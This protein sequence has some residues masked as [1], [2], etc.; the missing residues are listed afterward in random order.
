MT[1]G[2][3]TTRAAAAEERASTPNS[4]GPE[5]AA[6]GMG[7]SSERVG[8]V[9]PGQV[10]TDGVRD[11][12]ELDPSPGSRPDRDADAGEGA[13]EGI[14]PKAGYPSLDPRHE[15]KPYRT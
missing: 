14:E 13:V 12:S 15:D 6:G 2:D 1:S 9:G 3:D 8:H 11:T 5:G 10:G 7:S 4:S